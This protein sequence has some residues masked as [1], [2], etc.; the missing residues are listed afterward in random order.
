MLTGQQSLMPPGHQ[1]TL[2]LQ[3]HIISLIIGHTGPA[4]SQSNPLLISTDF[5][6]YP[7]GHLFQTEKKFSYKLTEFFFQCSLKFFFSY[8]S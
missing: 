2:P 5:L 1:V 7:F 3:D 4:A 8:R 6:K